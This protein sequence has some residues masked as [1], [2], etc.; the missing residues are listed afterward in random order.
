[1]IKH[2]LTISRRRISHQR[3]YFLMNTMALLY[4]NISPDSRKVYYND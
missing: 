3:A 4:K 2:Y 1:M